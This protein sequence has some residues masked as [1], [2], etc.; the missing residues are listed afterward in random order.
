MAL[1]KGNKILQITLPPFHQRK[2]ALICDKTG[3]NNS[4]VIQRWI[5]GHDL[6]SELLIQEEKQKKQEG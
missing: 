2:L 5:E 6:F 1:K 4:A 3:L